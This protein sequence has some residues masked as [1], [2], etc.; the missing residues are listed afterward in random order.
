MC[1]ID[2][3][4]NY[5]KFSASQVCINVNK[6]TEIF[7]Y[8]NLKCVSPLLCELISSLFHILN[9]EACTL[10]QVYVFMTV[11]FKMSKF[12]Q[13]P[14]ILLYKFQNFYFQKNISLNSQKRLLFLKMCVI[15]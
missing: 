9:R 1:N 11:A 12:F 4:N 14:T 15:L 5:T 2:T 10:V 8:S 13:S 7:M 3:Y 6:T